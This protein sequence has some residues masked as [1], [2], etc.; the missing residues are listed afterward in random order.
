MC[1][2]FFRWTCCAA[3]IA[4]LLV[5]ACIGAS[6][7]GETTRACGPV[8][9]K[10]A[11]SRTAF[12]A[13]EWE[14]LAGRFDLRF[15]ATS[16]PERGIQAYGS[17]SLTIAERAAGKR[18]EACGFSVLGG[19]AAV[20]DSLP[21][22]WL[23]RAG[24]DPLQVRY[25][26]E[27]AHFHLARNVSQASKNGTCL[28]VMSSALILSVDSV[29]PG[30]F[31]GEWSYAAEPPVRRVIDGTAFALPSGSFCALRRAAPHP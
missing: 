20:N 2:R 9:S 18:A 27:Q 8:T 7:S 19:Q 31:S 29:G 15:L 4:V 24:G 10:P 13:S 23:V 16:T 12:T 30:G 3:I 5:P 17:L 26:P 21:G 22:A 1:F 11:T 14:R 25:D 6:V 28:H